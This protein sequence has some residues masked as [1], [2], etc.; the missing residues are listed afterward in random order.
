MG[1]WTART[2]RATRATLRLPLQR[3]IRPESTHPSRALLPGE[4]EWFLRTLT[5]GTTGIQRPDESGMTFLGLLVLRDPPK[6]GVDQVVASLA[7]LGVSLKMITGDSALIAEQVA[8]N[9]GITTPVVLTGEAPDEYP[10]SVDDERHLLLV[11]VIDAADPDAIRA[12][13]AA[14]REH[15]LR[16]LVR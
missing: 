1:R 6:A 2:N 9:V 16:D 14:A 8:R 7:R 5:P 13:H 11:H 15:Y 3:L 12:R 4:T 10:V